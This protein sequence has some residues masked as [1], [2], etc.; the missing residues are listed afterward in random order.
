MFD[1][2]TFYNFKT[3]KGKEM[4]VEGQSAIVTGG[5]SGLGEATARLLAENGAKVT[6]L[7]INQER[8]GKIA[9]EIGGIYSSCDV[10]DEKSIQIGLNAA[11]EAQA[12]HSTSVLEIKK[13]LQ[14]LELLH[15][16][17]VL[18]PK[19][20]NA[21]SLRQGKAEISIQSCE[22]QIVRLLWRT[23]N[24]HQLQYFLGSTQ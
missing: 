18:T 22:I 16:L 10:N 17:I 11:K 24:T 8:G 19:A 1:L 23:C 20:E 9:G 21:A 5:A 7:D 6:I 3:I 2:L 13:Q 14:V 12:E 15:Q 4:N